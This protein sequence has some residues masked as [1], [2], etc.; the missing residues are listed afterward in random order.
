[1]QK[2]QWNR[3]KK[4]LLE[5]ISNY[6]KVAGYQVNIQKSIVFLY[7]FSERVE[8]YIKNRILFTLVPSKMK[9]LGVN[10]TK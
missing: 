8:F 4:N 10:L 2:I 9:Y 1:M 6:S 7:I 3:Q 5:L